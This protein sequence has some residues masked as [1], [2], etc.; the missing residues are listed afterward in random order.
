MSWE[1]YQT[2]II[3]LKDPPI[4]FTNPKF[5]ESPKEFYYLAILKQFKHKNFYLYNNHPNKINNFPF[6]LIFSGN[7][8]GV[9]WE[10]YHQS[11]VNI[12]SIGN[13]IESLEEFRTFELN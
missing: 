11:Q 7:H 4:N 3:S 8:D 13:T 10:N 12:G 9:W 5:P 2:P 1:R 6:S